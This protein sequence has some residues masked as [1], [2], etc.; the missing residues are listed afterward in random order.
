MKWNKLN[1]IIFITVSFL[2]LLNATNTQSSIAKENNPALKTNSPSPSNNAQN[3]PNN[4]QTTPIIKNR[5][6]RIATDHLLEDLFRKYATIFKGALNIVKFNTNEYTELS[7]I[8]QETCLKT[9]IKTIYQRNPYEAQ[10]IIAKR[11][12]NQYEKSI[13]QNKLIKFHMGYYAFLLMSLKQ[14]QQSE[15]MEFSALNLYKALAKNLPINNLNT[16]NKFTQWKEVDQ[17]LPNQPIKIYGPKINSAFFQDLQERFIIPA[18]ASHELYWKEYQSY[19]QIQKQCTNY[20]IDSI[21]IEDDD[22]HR[23]ALQK[24]TESENNIVVMPYHLYKRSL[25]NKI[26]FIT[27]NFNGASPTIHNIKLQKYNLSWP[28]YIYILKEELEQNPLL[29]KFFQ[30]IQLPENISEN[31]TL[32]NFGLIAK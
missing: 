30:E 12:L 4:T 2:I 29:Q 22:Q 31:G 8:L 27:H 21:Y 17:F 3:S 18:C 14:S 28:I 16:E 5:I 24:L 20:R 1:Q 10:V 9:D 32:S 19:D 15:S 6:I 7:I 11:D 13:C 25:N 26:N 23:L